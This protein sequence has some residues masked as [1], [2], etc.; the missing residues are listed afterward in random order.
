MGARSPGPRGGHSME[1]PARTRVPG[2]PKRPHGGEGNERT[3]LP[4]H[5]KRPVTPCN[6]I[7]KLSLQNAVRFN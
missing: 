1:R 4:C 5:F 6:C 7:R 2:H 3:T